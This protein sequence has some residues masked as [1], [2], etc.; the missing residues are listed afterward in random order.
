M[1]YKIMVLGYYILIVLEQ[2]NL[3]VGFNNGFKNESYVVNV[4]KYNFKIKILKMVKGVVLLL[5]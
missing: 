2:Y 4:L 5:F 1:Y 3:C